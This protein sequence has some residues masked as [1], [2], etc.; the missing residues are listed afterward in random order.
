[1][2]DKEGPDGPSSDEMCFSVG[3]KYIIE[4]LKVKIFSVVHFNSKKIYEPIL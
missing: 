2:V 3:L 1:M 4:T